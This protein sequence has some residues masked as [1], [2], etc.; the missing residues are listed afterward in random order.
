MRWCMRCQ[1]YTYV[2]LRAACMPSVT[3]VQVCVR[4]GVVIYKALRRFD[5]YDLR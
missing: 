5:V 4:Q 3:R 1:P 2:F